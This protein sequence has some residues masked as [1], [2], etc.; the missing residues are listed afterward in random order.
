MTI[1]KKVQKSS[2]GGNGKTPQRPRHL[3]NST[4]GNSRRNLKWIMKRAANRAFQSRSLRIRS[5]HIACEIYLDTDDIQLAETYYANLNAVLQ[6]LDFKIV[7]EKATEI[8]SW[9]KRFFAR[10]KTAITSKEVQ[11][12]LEKLE[13]GL[14]LQFID[15]V[16]SEV[17]LNTAQAIATLIDSTK[18]IPNFSTLVGSLLFAKATVNGE[19]IVF[20]QTLTHEQL[21][22]VRNNPGLINKPFDLVQKMEEE[23]MQVLAFGK[24]KQISKE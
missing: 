15:K 10:T 20:A 2:N 23:R 5:H 14:E 4:G 17:D 6:T 11:I 12:R 3:N 16:Q 19:Q 24:V 21:M 7:R 9:I 18:E 8:G 22:I 1:S 13:R